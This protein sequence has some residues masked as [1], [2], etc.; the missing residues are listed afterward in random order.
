MKKISD[1]LDQPIASRYFSIYEKGEKRYPLHQFLIFHG[2][3]G[4]GKSSVA[5]LFIK[6]FLCDK[7]SGCDE[8]PACERVNHNSH[9]DFLAFPEEKILI[10]DEKKP[11][12]YTIRWLKKSNLIY[13]S[14]YTGY[15]FIFFPNGNLIQNE[16]ESALLK[17][18]EEPPKNTIFLMILHQREKMRSTILSRAFQIPFFTL[19]DESITQISQINDPQHLQ[20][21]GGTLEW[22]GLLRSSF[23]SECKEKITLATQHL[24]DLLELEIWLEKKLMTLGK[25]EYSD[26]NVLNFFTLILLQSFDDHSAKEKLLSTIFHC[27]RNLQL[28][29][30]LEKRGLTP[31]IL[32]QLFASLRFY[33]Y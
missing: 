26:Y 2:P 19:S 9:P 32:G 16:A 22:V 3:A 4:V 17:I 23:Y 25:K 1:L 33:L 20:L 6:K 12:P 5:R 15:R 28:L 13:H 18:L 11:L 7:Q 10:G 29:S 21:L 30:H 8:C 14:Y 27:R 24:Q 31:Y